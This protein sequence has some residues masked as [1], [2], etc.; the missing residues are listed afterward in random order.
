[1]Q[2]SEYIR[3]LQGLIDSFDEHITPDDIIVALRDMTRRIEEEGLEYEPTEPPPQCEA[4]AWIGQ[5]F[6]HCDNCGEPYWEHTHEH[7]VGSQFGTLVPITPE[8]ASRVKS[9]WGG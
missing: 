1:M 5:S 8:G 9:K 3:E 4:F 6:R 2:T 7:G